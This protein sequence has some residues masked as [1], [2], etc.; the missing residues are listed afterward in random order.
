MQR[1]LQQATAGGRL[2][3]QL[4]AQQVQQAG[5]RAYRHI[6]HHRLDLGTAAFTQVAQQVH[7]LHLPSLQA[8]EVNQ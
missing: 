8:A 2:L 4:P 7:R 3:L 1:V 5:L 6:L